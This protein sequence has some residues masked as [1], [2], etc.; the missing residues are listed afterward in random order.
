MGQDGADRS[1]PSVGSGVRLILSSDRGLSGQGRQEFAVGEPL[2]EAHGP[3]AGGG[4][5]GFAAAKAVAGAGI[6]VELGGDAGFFEEQVHVGEAFG[7]VGAVVVAGGEED[8]R[9]AFLGG[10]EGGFAGIDQSLEIGE[11]RASESVSCSSGDWMS[12]RSC[13]RDWDGGGGE[14]TGPVGCAGGFC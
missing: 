14:E 2:G 7:D 5:V 9:G 11:A 12:C 10:D 6:K 4:L 8:G 3:G 13:P 1:C